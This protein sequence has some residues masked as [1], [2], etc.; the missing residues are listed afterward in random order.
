MSTSKR[1]YLEALREKKLFLIGLLMLFVA[2][3]T[4]LIGPMIAMHILDKYVKKSTVLEVNAIL[5]L[6][7]LY[8]IVAVIYAIFSYYQ[9]IYF[10]T[11]GSNVIKNLRISLFKHAQKL[12]IHY[13]DNLP[14][15]KVV[16]RITNDTQ[17]ILELFT[18]M[19][20]SYISG[21]VNIT[22]IIIVI[23]IFNYKVGLLA[24][25]VVPLLFF[26][27]MY[28]RKVSDQYNRIVRE[29]NSDMNAMLNESINGM[30]IIQAFNQ[31][32]KIYREFTDLNDEYLKNYEKIIKLDSYTSHN[33][34]GTIRSVVFLI[35]I[36]IFGV[37]YLGKEMTLTVGM[38]YILV[39]Y[40][41]RLFNPLFNMVNQL[42]LLEQARVSANRVFEMMDET[43]EPTESDAFKSIKGHVTFNHVNFEYK[44]NEPVLKDINIDANIGDTIALVGHT[45][46]GKSSIMNLLF[47]FYDPT[48]G[49]ILID[50]HDT[51]K[52]TKSSMRKHMAIV[53]QDPYL[54]TGTILSNITLNDERVSR[55]AA[56][57]AL[58]K[59]GGDRVLQS[60]EQGIDTP[61]VE[62]GSTLSSGQKQLISF[63]RALAFNP[64]I[65]ILDEATASIDS[66]TESIIQNAMDVVKE[67][68]TTFIIA[69]RLS[70]IKNATKI[71]VLDKGEIIESGTH[72]ELIALGGQYAKMYQLQSA[73]QSSAL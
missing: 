69:H 50:G 6:L 41:T 52:M 45:G 62:K 12:P 28:Y 54:Y 57:E 53:L 2:V 73:R 55:E 31:E 10:Q 25:I 47:R 27:L 58:H 16:A 1:L 56:I 24:L 68:R 17:T 65:L 32:E 39:D 7:G 14:A 70:T 71:I 11:A 43:K 51:T 63:A 36:Y 61:V 64:K 38:M 15:G 8:M 4:E 49:Q 30:T 26:W 13:F 72:D 22:G 3:V 34:M 46:S 23:F 60:L 59:V 44:P 21:I 33:L 66:E 42:S 35:M 5:Q 9:T 19:L 37:S 20:P 40:L 67:G 29:R 18:V 48:E